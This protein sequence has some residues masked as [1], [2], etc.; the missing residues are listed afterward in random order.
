MRDLGY[1]L[2]QN[3]QAETRRVNEA[4]FVDLYHKTLLD[5]GVSSYS[6]ERCQNDYRLGLLLAMWVPLIGAQA[7]ED[8]E[9][10]KPAPVRRFGRTIAI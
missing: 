10:R 2:G 7:L 3:L 1:F 4:A 6:R 9:E 5:H 8:I